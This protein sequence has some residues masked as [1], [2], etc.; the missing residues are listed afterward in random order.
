MKDRYSIY[1]A[2]ARLSEVI[3]LVKQNQTVIITERGHEV[4]RMVPIEPK[5]SF[6]KR[7]QALAQVGIITQNPSAM[8]GKITTIARRPGSLKR[9]LDSRDRY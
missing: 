1:E 7:L 5:S 2:K 4:A 8:P 9:F 6:D 3:R